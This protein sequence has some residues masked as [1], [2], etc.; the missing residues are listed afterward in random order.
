MNSFQKRTASATFWTVSGFG[1]AQIMRFGGNLILA[2]LLIPEDFG[3]MALVAIFMQ[4]LVMFSDVGLGPSIIRSKRGEDPVFLNTAWTIQVFRGISLW[5]C[6][7]ILAQPFADYYAQQSFELLI[8]VACLTVLF[9]GFESTAMHTQNRLLNVRPVMIIETT[10]Q[11]IGLTLM[12]AWALYYPSIWALVAGG[13]ASSV[14]KMVFSHFLSTPVRNTFHWNKS[15]AKELVS[16]GKW[17]FL[18]TAVTFSANQIDRLV[19]GKLVSLEILGIYSIAYMW[20]RAPLQLTTLWCSRVFMAATA[21]LLREE[22][23][24]VE[25]ILAYRRDFLYFIMPPSAALVVIAPSLI[26]FLYPP[27]YGLAGL[28]ISILLSGVWIRS[29]EGSYRSILIV[30]GRPELVALGNTVAVV[31]FVVA[32]FPAY[33]LWGVYGVALASAGSQIGLYAVCSYGAHKE[34]ISS[35]RGD[36]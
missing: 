21:K 33:D 7:V 22:K 28:I 24:A 36:I 8:P 25:Q 12:I 27:V 9:A 1:I 34:K 31:L 35:I 30:I 17:I 19:L 18:S 3:M 4:G 15:A 26:E 2:R 10:S 23:G 29:L 32:V 20:A 16:F 14:S 13:L 6:A 5:A 11:A